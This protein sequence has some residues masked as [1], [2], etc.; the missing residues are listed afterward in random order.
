MNELQGKIKWGNKTIPVWIRIAMPKALGNLI[1]FKIEHRI[2]FIVL[3][4]G[5]FGIYSSN[6]AAK[7]LQ[8]M[9]ISHVD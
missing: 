8:Y 3:D 9:C 4:H 2:R 5:S 1:P 7:W 6:Y